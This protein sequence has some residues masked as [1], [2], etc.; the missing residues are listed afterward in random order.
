MTFEQLMDVLPN[1]L[2]DSFLKNISVD[3]I[4]RKISASIDIWVGNL[5]SK[6]FKDREELRSAQLIINDF[7]FC[8]LDAPD[9]TYQ[10]SQNKPLSIDAG[11]GISPTSK[12]KLPPIK[13]D[14][15]LFWV[16]V[17]Q[18]N[19]V[20]HIAARD[21]DLIRDKKNETF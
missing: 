13:K 16:W 7:D 20:I 10:Y 19:S 21:I 17:N 6:D 15:F 14:H 1:G 3:Y 5:D 8:T 11:E 12:I 4:S 18:W 9:A 2:H